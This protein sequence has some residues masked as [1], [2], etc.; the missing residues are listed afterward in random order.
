[1]EEKGIVDTLF[2]TEPLLRVVRL[3]IVHTVCVCVCLAVRGYDVL[4]LCRRGCG[5]VCVCM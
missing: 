1:M 4:C 3:Y 5:D 2:T